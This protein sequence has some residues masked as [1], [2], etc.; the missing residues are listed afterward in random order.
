MA[1]TERTEIGSRDVLVSGAIQVR[2]DTVIE[3]DGIEISR[4]YHRHV[5]APG[6]SITGEDPAVQRIAMAEHTPAKI[7][8]YKLAMEKLTI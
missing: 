3:R 4:T 7:A 8:A 1:L 6:D 2:R 5:L